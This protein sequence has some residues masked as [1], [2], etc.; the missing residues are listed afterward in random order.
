MNAL[1]LIA[2][3][4]DDAIFAYTLQSELSCINWTIVSL[5]NKASNIRG[6]EL[7][8]YQLYMGTD[9]ENI[10]FLNFYDNRQDNRERK[11]WRNCSIDFASAIDKLANLKL[12]PGLILTHNYVGEYGHPHHMLCYNLAR[13]C[14]TDTNTMVFG[15]GIENHTISIPIRENK[16][17]VIERFYKSQKCVASVFEDEYES[18]NNIIL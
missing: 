9:R 6:G 1:L 10:H 13:V 3:P 14:F 15:K 11:Q 4:D 17:E 12:N 18:F 7:I 8:D 5:T 2:H 16:Q